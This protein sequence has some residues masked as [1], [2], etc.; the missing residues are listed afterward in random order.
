MKFADSRITAD[1]ASQ[2]G[3]VTESVSHNNFQ[4]VV[5]QHAT[6]MARNAQ[7]CRLIFYYFSVEKAKYCTHK[8][9]PE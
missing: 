5:F 1:V 4:D 8:A 3:L 6:V 7:V 2:F 9:S